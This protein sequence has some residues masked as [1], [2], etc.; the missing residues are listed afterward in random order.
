MNE[1]EEMRATRREAEALQTALAAND[2][3]VRQFLGSAALV[4]S[5]YTQAL[6]RVNTELRALERSFQTV[7]A[8]GLNAFAGML[9][10]IQPAV[11]GFA[12][13]GHCQCPQQGGKVHPIGG[14]G[15]EGSVQL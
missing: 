1:I 9:N 13:L 2:Q 11:E 6:G 10:A 7:A 4:Q 8:V 15:A 12:S 3:A 5:A 14:S